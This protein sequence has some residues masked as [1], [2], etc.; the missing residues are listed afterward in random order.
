MVSSLEGIP[1][2]IRVLFTIPSI[3]SAMTAEKERLTSYMCE[4]TKWTSGTVSV[5][6]HVVA[7]G[8]FVDLGG[9][10]KRAKVQTRQRRE[11][12]VLPTPNG[13]TSG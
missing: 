7:F 11:G 2:R 9:Q 3:I 8:R 6:P 4:R 12:L 10:D 13:L 1:E 5:L